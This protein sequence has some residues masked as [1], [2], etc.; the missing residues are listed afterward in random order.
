MGIIIVN[1]P[2]YLYLLQCSKYRKG[3]NK[4]PWEALD[5]ILASLDTLGNIILCLNANFRI[6]TNEDYL[7][8]SDIRHHNLHIDLIPNTHDI[9]RRNNAD[10]IT[11]AQCDDLI[12]L[13]IS[14]DIR[15]LNG[16]T[17]GD[18]LGKKTYICSKGSSTIDYIIT[19]KSIQDRVIDF[20]VRPFTEYSDHRPIVTRISMHLPFY[21]DHSV[22]SFEQKPNRFKWLD[23][24]NTVFLSTLNTVSI[25]NQFDDI[26]GTALTY[27]HEQCQSL[28]EKFI[29]AL[30]D[31]S[32]NCLVRTKY[33]ENL[34]HKKWFS[35]PCAKAKRNLN[36]TVRRLNKCVD[37][38]KLKSDY[39]DAKRSYKNLITT[40][41]LNYRSNLNK[42]IENGSVTDWSKY[43]TLKQTFDTPD[44][45]DN[46][47]LAVFYEFFKKLYKQTTDKNLPDPPSITTCTNS[48]FISD[49]LIELNEPFSETEIR[50]VAQKLKNGKSVSEDLISNEMLK[51]LNPAGLKALAHLFNACMSSGIYPWHNSI[52]SP[53]HKSGDRYNPD[54]YR[55]IAVSSCIGKLFSSILLN[56]LVLFRKNHCPDPVNQLGFCKDAQTNDHMFTLKTIIDKY[57]KKLRKKLYA[58]FVD[59]KKAFDSVSREFLLLKIANLGISGNFF[60]A[61]KNMYNNSRAKVKLGK[62]LSPSFDIEKGTE[63]GH[64]MSP[65]LFKMYMLDLTNRLSTNGNFPHLL[66]S[67]INHLLWADDLVLLALDKQ[68]LQVILDILHNFCVDWGLEVNLKKTKILAFGDRKCKFQFNIGDNKIDFAER[69]CYLGVVF[70][71][72]GSFNPALSE[73][74]KKSVRAFFGIKRYIMR[75]SL[76]YDGLIKLFNALIKP[77]LLYSCQIIAP[78]TFLSR[79]ISTI[80]TPERYF[81][82]FKNDMYE[83]FQLKTL[84][85]SCGV[86]KNHRI[87]VY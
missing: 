73:L 61:I 63:Q 29:K 53:I 55:A 76:S 82:I 42:S 33:V 46:F 5:E 7:L 20:K 69:Y 12:D 51:T 14:H 13:V 71:I 59:L 6:G 24:S 15:I 38:H 3:Q 58:C 68:S 77:V 8:D 44:Q 19:S 52:I 31:A 49:S 79:N 17:C 2:Y 18:Y 21:R 11:N 50:N 43:K 28:N 57:R 85:W 56:R 48:E 4:D 47:D 70:D 30:T 39:F 86:H 35:R 62:Y 81:E 25:Q 64:P 10:K 65:E 1:T 74:R 75:D 40:T 9:R 27:N 26:A 54:N 16:R 87:S 60:E 34:P 84:K 32:D 67:I 72:N 66:D 23:D 41:K 22:Y 45:F 37:N 36:K 80:I 83:K 78:H